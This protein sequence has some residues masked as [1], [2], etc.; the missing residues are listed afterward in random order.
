MKMLRSTLSCEA[1]SDQGGREKNEDSMHGFHVGDN[2]C[3]IVADG[4]GGHGDGDVASKAAVDTIKRWW[5]GSVSHEAWRELL[6][7]AHKEIQRLQTPAKQMKTTLVGLMLEDERAVWAHV[8]D[9]RLYHFH[10]GKIVFQTQDH[11]ASQIAVMLGEITQDQIRFSEG[12][13]TVIK[14][15]GQP[16]EAPEPQIHEEIL[17]PGKHAFLLC[18]DGFWEYVLENEME[19][20]LASAKDAEQWLK[21]MR[22]RLNKRVPPGNDNNTAIAIWL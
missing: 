19:E 4:L 22:V 16:G 8:G 1:Y 17:E 14:A 7:L 12:R 11:S 18:T 9:S 6:E 21:A 3:F 10:N 5:D 20:D 13:S 15:L 2:V